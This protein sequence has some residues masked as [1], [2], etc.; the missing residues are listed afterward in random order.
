MAL[1]G[2]VLG[3]QYSNSDKGIRDFHA[4]YDYLT[5][6]KRQ[7]ALREIAFFRGLGTRK[8]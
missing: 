4:F 8:S 5:L 7:N 6:T 1:V 2:E 3:T